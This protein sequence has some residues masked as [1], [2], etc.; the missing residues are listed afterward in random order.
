MGYNVKTNRLTVGGR[1]IPTAAEVGG[2]IKKGAGDLVEN[3]GTVG[4]AL[5]EMTYDTFQSN[6]R[7]GALVVGV[8]GEPKSLKKGGTVKKTGLIK[9]HKGEKVIPAKKRKKRCK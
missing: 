7:K 9:M 1:K 3:L 4:R 8:S 2:A 5:K 6:P